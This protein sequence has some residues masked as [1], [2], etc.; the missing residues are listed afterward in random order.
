MHMYLFSQREERNHFEFLEDNFIQCHVLSL[1]S[2][3]SGP[4]A[5]VPA[6]QLT[7]QQQSN[8]I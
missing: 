8:E 1:T 3:L 2:S 6:P 7:K 5:S 4:H